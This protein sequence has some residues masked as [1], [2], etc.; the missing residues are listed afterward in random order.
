MQD[1]ILKEIIFDAKPYSNF[2]FENL[3]VQLKKFTSSIETT[4]NVVL[5]NYGNEQN[6]DTFDNLKE[7][8]ETYKYYCDE[9]KNSFH[10][11]AIFLAYN[12]DKSL[13]FAIYKYEEIYKI[14]GNKGVVLSNNAYEAIDICMET[15]EKLKSKLKIEVKGKFLNNKIK[16]LDYQII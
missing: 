13:Y 10:K 4:Y 8:I 3:G 12:W 16:K 2:K 9:I 6:Y 11:K 7:A 5:Y 14:I 15:I 1:K